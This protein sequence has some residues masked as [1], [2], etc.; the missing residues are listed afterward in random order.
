MKIVTQLLNMLS[1]DSLKDVPSLAEDLGLPPREVLKMLV[2]LR[3]TKTV[4]FYVKD[5]DFGWRLRK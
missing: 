5:E 2:S 4:G 1:F 3:E